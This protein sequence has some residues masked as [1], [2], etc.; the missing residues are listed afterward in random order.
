MKGTFTFESSPNCDDEGFKWSLCTHVN[1]YLN[2]MA[3]WNNFVLEL[4]PS[5]GEFGALEII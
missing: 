2:L 5:F 3:F 1:A 4:V